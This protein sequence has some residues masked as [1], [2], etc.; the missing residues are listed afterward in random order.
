MAVTS[1]T[2]TNFIQRQ[3]APPSLVLA[4]ALDGDPE[5]VQKVA[6]GDGGPDVV[7]TA[8]ASAADTVNF[9]IPF[10][11]LLKLYA[12][13]V[14]NQTV[15]IC[16]ARVFV[17]S[18]TNV[19]ANGYFYEQWASFGD[20]AG[21]M[22]LLEQAATPATVASEGTTAT[23]APALTNNGSN[24]LRVA[25]VTTG[26]TNKTVRCELTVLQPQ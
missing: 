23:A 5:A 1:S 12:A 22:T 15:L 19:A 14:A 4:Q 24:T 17:Y 18:D 16:K 25:I 3:P 13:Q 7:F 6:G 11:S 2:F 26:A 20:I 8:R 9:D 21:T 10:A